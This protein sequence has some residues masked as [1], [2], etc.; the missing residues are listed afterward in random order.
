VIDTE[1]NVLSVLTESCSLAVFNNVLF[2]FR[3]ACCHC[4]TTVGK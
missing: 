4:M 3:E 1:V 2:C